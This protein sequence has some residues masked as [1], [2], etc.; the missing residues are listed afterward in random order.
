MG[1]KL[2]SLKGWE[3]L[4]QL[5]LNEASYQVS[6]GDTCHAFAL[7]DVPAGGSY[8]LGTHFGDQ[9]TVVLKGKVML[10]HEANCFQEPKGQF[11]SFCA[12]GW[13]RGAA[14]LCMSILETVWAFGSQV[15]CVEGGAR[16]VKGWTVLVIPNDKHIS[17][18]G[19]EGPLVLITGRRGTC[20]QGLGKPVHTA[21][22]TPW[23]CLPRNKTLLYTPL[24]FL[25]I[26]WEFKKGIKLIWDLGNDVNNIWKFRKVMFFLSFLAFAYDTPCINYILNMG[27]FPYSSNL[28]YFTSCLIRN[29]VLIYEWR[30]RVQEQSFTNGFCLAV[31]NHSALFF[32][33]R[34]RFHN[35]FGEWCF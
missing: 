10:I 20:G 17:Q 21:V 2:I 35:N 32:L 29:L 15:N 8:H 30:Q 6:I 19:A 13:G 31:V 12:G 4:V 9:K 3:Q 23:R 18:E 5:I 28:V 11:L 27:I 16:Y 14:H 7:R 26:N 34:C 24:L 22:P 33:N 25:K 1:Y